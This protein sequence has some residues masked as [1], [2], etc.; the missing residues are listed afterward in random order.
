MVYAHYEKRHL[1]RVFDQAS[2]SAADLAA[3][4][5]TEQAPRR[6]GPHARE[7]TPID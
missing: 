6:A 1:R 2:V 3:Q 7:E 5:E 4:L